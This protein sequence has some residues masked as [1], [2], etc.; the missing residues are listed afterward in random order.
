MN[1]STKSDQP[2]TVS[3][4]QDWQE[5]TSSNPE[6]RRVLDESLLAGDICSIDMSQLEPE[7]APTEPQ[8]TLPRKPKV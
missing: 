7:N 3:G 1:S 2:V 4:Y 6:L 5:M 8:T